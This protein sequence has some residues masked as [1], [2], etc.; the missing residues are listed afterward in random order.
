MQVTK[1]T[2]RIHKQCVPGSLFSSL[3]QEPGNEASLQPVSARQ[4]SATFNHSALPLP[5]ISR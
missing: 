5:N 4:D 2:W 3:A 1:G